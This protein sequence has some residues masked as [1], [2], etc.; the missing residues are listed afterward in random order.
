MF[1]EEAH[2]QLVLCFPLESFESLVDYSCLPLVTVFYG[3]FLL[4][5]RNKPTYVCVAHVK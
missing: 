3:L 4:L 1:S 5:L 2:F